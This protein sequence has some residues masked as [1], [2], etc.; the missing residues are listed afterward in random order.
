M[1]SRKSVRVRR[2]FP[3]TLL[4]KPE[5]ITDARGRAQ[6]EVPLAAS[7]TTWRLA[8][9]AVSKA[10][11]L[12]SATQ[13]IR[14]FQD[15]FVDIDFPGAL[16]QHDQVSVPVAG[17]NYLDKPQTVQLEVQEGAWFEL[18]GEAKQTLELKA[19]EV[20]GVSFRLEALKPGTH[21]LTVKA[22]GSEMDDAVHRQVRVEPDG[23]RME[24][25]LN[26]RLDENLNRRLEIPAH[27]IEGA[28]DLFV[29][30]YRS[31]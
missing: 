11:E 28:N 2:H 14:V 29:K 30:I 10:G 26:G 25:V 13:G 1:T 24:Q 27:A 16:T 20:K 9:S 4:W 3:E 5:L 15:F 7:I 18:M 8:M 12:G 17:Y 21:A 22:S 6:L 31:I 23:R 19:R